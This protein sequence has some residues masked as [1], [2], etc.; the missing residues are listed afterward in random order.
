M[1][2]LGLAL[3]VIGGVIL[4]IGA[5]V[6]FSTVTSTYA[7]N[8][9]D[10]AAQDQ[11]TANEAKQ[12]CG[13]ISSARYK[14]AT[15]TLTTASDCENAKSFMNRQLVMGIVPTVIGGLMS[16]IGLATFLIFMFR[17]RTA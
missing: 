3:F 5:V 10:R 9:C 6:I 1:K 13:D 7:T 15:R 16:V 14:E 4:L 8:A 12:R 17:K 11:K 2:I